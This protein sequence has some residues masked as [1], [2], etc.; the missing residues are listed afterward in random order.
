M[1]APRNERNREVPNLLTARI[2]R[3]I[4]ENFPE[5]SPEL[6]QD[7]IVVVELI[8]DR[9]VRVAILQKILHE[10][11]EELF[12]PDF[13]ASPVLDLPDD[14]NEGDG[15]QI[16]FQ[17]K[18]GDVTHL[19]TTNE[20]DEVIKPCAVR[21]KNWKMRI[22]LHPSAIDSDDA[23][24]LLGKHRYILPVIAGLKPA[25]YLRT[26]PQPDVSNS[27]I[28]VA[29]KLCDRYKFLKLIKIAEDVVL[30][31]TEAVKMKARKCPDAFEGTQANLEDEN[32]AALFKKMGT[33]LY[34][35]GIV[36]GFDELSVGAFS[37]DLLPE[38]GKRKMSFRNIWS[39]GFVVANKQHPEYLKLKANY[40]QL[41]RFVEER[42]AR[43]L[44]VREVVDGL[45][46]IF[47]IR[48]ICEDLADKLEIIL[49]EQAS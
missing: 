20:T 29:R 48:E 27:Q 2:Y 26:G 10:L 46:N 34:L 22:H 18:S 28:D 3:I 37:E 43:G 7:N 41:Q 16:I 13:Y 47:V 9:N 45:Q 33:D 38:V 8:M 42:L 11:R 49:N 24:I 36:L 19:I 25:C 44:T 21:L 32:Y 23:Q 35:E 31:N 15:F 30:F 40:D 39:V 12:L 5:Y 14:A 4:A 6:L 1:S 17:A